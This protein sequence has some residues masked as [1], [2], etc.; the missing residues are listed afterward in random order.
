MAENSKPAR[1]WWVVAAVILLLLGSFVFSPART[2][3]TGHLWD[4]LIKMHG[5]AKA[6][7]V[8]HHP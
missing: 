6:G 5:G 7:G 3:L 1:K 8:H 2:W 4:A